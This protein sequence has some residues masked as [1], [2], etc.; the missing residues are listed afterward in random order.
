MRIRFASL[1]GVFGY[2]DGGFRDR[3]V[4]ERTADANQSKTLRRGV[5]V[6]LAQCRTI[7]NFVRPGCQNPELHEDNVLDA[8]R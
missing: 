2:V 3:L 1:V 5:S 8:R 7:M 4:A 6:H